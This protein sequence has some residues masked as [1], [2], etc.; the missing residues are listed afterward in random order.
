MRTV[1][2]LRLTIYMALFSV[3]AGLTLTTAQAAA[4]S[5][6]GY[7][8]GN[9]A[10]WDGGFD[11]DVLKGR[12]KNDAIPS[13]ATQSKDGFAN[14]IIGRLNNGDQREKTG[15]AFIIN[16]MVRAGTTGNPSK[17]RN[18]SSTMRQEWR[19]RLMDDKIVMQL[20]YAD[21]NSYS[22][23]TSFYDP[24]INDDFFTTYNSGSRSLLVFRDK[25][26]GT[27]YYVVEVPCANPLGGLPGLPPLAKWQV[28]A[29]SSV[30]SPNVRPGQSVTF[31]HNVWHTGD[32]TPT[33]TGSI[34]W[35]QQGTNTTD[36]IIWGTNYSRSFGTAYRATRQF[37]IPS[38]AQNGWKYCQK[39]SF[40]PS[41]ANNNGQSFSNAACAVVGV[42][43]PADKYVIIRG[44]VDS[45]PD[46]E[47]TE[48]TTA[49]GRANVTG[50]PQQTEYGY[51][52]DAIQADPKRVNAV[53]KP[54]PS[55]NSLY[56]RGSVSSGTG[57]RTICDQYGWIGSG[58]SRYWGCIKSHQENYT[59][60][61]CNT[62]GAYSESGPPYCPN[63]YRHTCSYGQS[64]WIDT[65]STGTCTDRWQCP[66]PSGRWY[67]QPA[68]PTNTCNIWRCQYPDAQNYYSTNATKYDCD[69]RCSNGA[70][71]PALLDSGPKYTN[72]VIVNGSGHH[73]F[74]KPQFTLTCV[75]DDGTTVTSIVTQDGTYCDSNETITGT[76]IG[77]VVC[78]TIT[79]I[80]PSGWNTSPPPGWAINR[81]VAHWGFQVFPNTKCANVAG[82]P[83]FKVY[84]GD[85][86]SGGGIKAASTCSIF[87]SAR[88]LGWNRNVDNDFSGAGTQFAAQALQDIRGF[89]T[90]QYN[91]G[92]PFVNN[93]TGLAF[94]NTGA[95]PGIGLFGGYFGSTPPCI[96]Y[97]N[98]VPSGTMTTYG[99]QT[100]TG[101]SLPNGSAI[102]RHV[103]G[104]VYIAGNI[105]YQNGPWA[106]LGDVPSYKLVVEGNIY[107]SG[108]V[109]QLDGLYVAVPNS[110]G[111]GGT[112]YTCATGIGAVPTT[113]YGQC[114]R[115]LVVNGSFVA[116]DVKLLRGCG[117][118]RR[119][120]INESTVQSGG[121]DLQYCSAS[122]HG[123]EVF[124]YSA[125][126]WLSVLKGP[127]PDRYDAVTSLPPVL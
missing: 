54:Y 79:P 77:D 94:A 73:C 119:S 99:S 125:I 78:A 32:T 50:F 56:M 62:T 95:N 35:D 60:W 117:T 13:Y 123:A 23:R 83:Y 7:F 11:G 26:T 116:K 57:T 127:L 53:N 40:K 111:T 110:S 49:Y 70:G 12:P 16:T 122:N 113:S 4:Y 102:T 114:D 80:M 64:A 120:M 90:A 76:D 15:A 88:I 51:N 65:N 24:S 31:S 100:L 17:T 98:R 66:S 1:K 47:P 86:V 75:W 38:N 91:N 109:T 5:G 22:S 93:A 58:A 96:D 8:T 18:P 89:A 97:V 45:L 19:D 20:V 124:N 104:D 105:T 48:T 14:F 87:S 27:A 43:P 21:P 74:V 63:L 61:Q 36:Q 84:G 44:A 107:I 30:S 85:V 46:I 81:F 29:S 25:N 2:P 37:T 39:I 72:T 41:S 59:Y 55:A 52:E 92:N 82:K 3:F 9:S 103:K 101:T 106:R 108:S 115:Q 67:Y 10:S 6:T 126:D 33:I 34:Y 118:L 121:S 69:F 71:Q 28:L 42:S 68:D 112:I